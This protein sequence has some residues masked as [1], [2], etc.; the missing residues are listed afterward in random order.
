MFDP[1]I[2]SQ[3]RE[4]SLAHVSSA[5]LVALKRLLSAETDFIRSTVIQAQHLCSSAG[6]ADAD[7]ATPIHAGRV[8]LAAGGLMADR[9]MARSIPA[10]LQRS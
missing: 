3:M 2:C 1:G 8:V 6:G 4:E 10:V 9:Q 7:Q 5:A